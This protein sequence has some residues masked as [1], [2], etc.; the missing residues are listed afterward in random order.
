MFANKGRN[1][2]PPKTHSFLFVLSGDPSVFAGGDSLVFGEEMAEGVDVVKAKHLGH[3]AH[4]ELA[5]TQKTSCGG[6]KQMLFV[7]HRWHTHG[8]F[9]CAPKL[10][11][12]EMAKICQLRRSYRLCVMLFQVSER[13]RCRTLGVFVWLV[14]AALGA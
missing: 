14:V 2:L 8:G 9:E 5:H 10:G 13:N 12:A 6:V 4:A 11:L 1:V 3:L 7:G